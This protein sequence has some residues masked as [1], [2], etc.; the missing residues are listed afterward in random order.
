ME[1]Q[2]VVRHDHEAGG[3]AP[4]SGV[5]DRK[6]GHERLAAAVTASQELDAAL[7]AAGQLE[8]AVDLAALLLDADCKGVDA[9]FGHEPLAQGLEDVVHV[10]AGQCAHGAIP[11]RT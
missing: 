11:S 9:A 1:V 3:K 10:P 5:E 6:A 8:L 4:F 7:A 2:V